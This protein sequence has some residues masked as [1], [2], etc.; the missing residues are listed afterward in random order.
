MPLVK[1][2]TKGQV[3]IP[4]KIRDGLG[5]AEGDL[6]EIDIQNGRGVIMPRRVVAAAPAP[7]LS[8]KEQRALTRAQKK[9]AAMKKDLVN[10]KGLTSDEV[11]VAA[12]VDLI[13]PDQ[14]YWWTEEWQ[15]GER[16]ADRDIRAG[17]GEVF[18]NPKDFLES[19]A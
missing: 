11:D 15:E 9:I 19:L 1:V 3:T 12:K 17:R 13:D 14:K 8:A 5:I 6:V 7:K 18:D 4:K 2:K 16:E 10:S